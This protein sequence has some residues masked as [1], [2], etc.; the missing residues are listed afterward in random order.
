MSSDNVQQYPVQHTFFVT[1]TD[2]EVGKTFVSCA[3]LGAC[4]DVGLSTAAYK[5]V[6]AGCERRAQGLRNDDA[7]LLQQVSSVV[8]GY[9]EVNPVAFEEPIAPHLACAKQ[10]ANGEGKLIEL[11]DI[12]LGYQHLVNKQSD[13]LLVEGAGGWRLPLGKNS[14]GREQFLSDFAIAQ[15]LPVILVVGMRLGCVNHALLTAQAIEHDGLVVAGWVANVLG[16]DMPFLQEN[17]QSL[18][19][20]LEAPLVARVPSASSPSDVKGCF[21]M[22]ALGFD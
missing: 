15:Q 4:N 5:P 20:L 22:R 18:Q 3:L 7:M 2:T 19:N 13:V 21:D 17:I 1:G 8:L 16:A 6:S 14:Q 11:H 12:N 10:I 9:E